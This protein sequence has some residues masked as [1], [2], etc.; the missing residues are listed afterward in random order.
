LKTLNIVEI[1]SSRKWIGEA[2]HVFNLSLNLIRRG[3]KVILITKRGWDL[4]KKADN[5]GLPNIPLI[6]NGHFNIR[7]NLRD[8]SELI[9]IFRK[10]KIDIIHAHRGHD[11]WLAAIALT[12]CRKKIPLVRTRHVN[13][14]VKN[15]IFNKWLYRYKTNK[16]I[17]VA[18][19]I[20]EGLAK[21]NKLPQ[22]K[23]KVIY[24]GA[25]TEVFN[26][27]LSGKKVRREFGIPENSPVIGLVGRISPIKGQKYLLNAIPAIK[28]DFPDARFILAGDFTSK[29][30]FKNLQ[31]LIENL[32]IKESVIFT[33]FREDIPEIIASFDIGVIASRGSEG[34]SR[35]CYEFM[36][37]KKSIIATNVGIMPEIIEDG[38]NGILIPP[39]DSLSIASAI[40]KILEDRTLGQKMGEAAYD[41][42]ITKF[43]FNIWIDKTLEAFSETL[44]LHEQG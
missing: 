11:H 22:N 12:I 25:D 29:E 20:K 5:I 16:I 10:E 37:M 42:L 19:H 18:N 35:V 17:C 27:K 14:Q 41:S 33:G 39:E 8:I 1:I 34:S 6:M 21:H 15:H 40:K 7:D 23:L 43:N 36:A 38:I 4:N 9:S 26:Y 30:T 13:V 28:K 32:G 3:H 44:L 2:S 31:S 24:T